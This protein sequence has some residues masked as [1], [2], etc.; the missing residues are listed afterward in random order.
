MDCTEV[1]NKIHA[2]IDRESVA[3]METDQLQSHFQTC[4]G[5]RKEFDQLEALHIRMQEFAGR[6]AVPDGLQARLRQRLQADHGQD[7]QSRRVAETGFTGKMLDFR[8][9]ANLAVAAA[10]ALLLLAVV[11]LLNQRQ[12]PQQVAVVPSVRSTK[13]TGQARAADI[14]AHFG[15]GIDV[16]TSSVPN[17]KA[18]AEAAGFSLKPPLLSGFKLANG[19]VC[20]VAG[21]RFVRLT[22][23]G[24]LGGKKGTLVC[25]ICPTGAFDA[26]GLDTHIIDGRKVCCGQMSELSL[27]YLPAKV[28]GNDWVLVAQSS[29]SDLMDVA[30]KT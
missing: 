8:R 5:C 9:P 6:V 4:S 1:R 11:P 13:A 23:H 24:A 28:Q 22:Y 25:Y 21:K 12:Q 30:L 16:Q 19:E 27:V 15:Q 10:A 14:V 2:V 20:D 7:L 29:K 17:M 18:L 3:T 26:A